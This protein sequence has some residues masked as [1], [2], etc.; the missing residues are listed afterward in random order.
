MRRQLASTAKLCDSI[1]ANAAGDDGDDGDDTNAALPSF[2]IAAETQRR[3]AAARVRLVDAAHS[4]LQD[5]RRASPARNS[6][7]P[8]A[9]TQGS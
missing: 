4:V 9:R 7:R 6:S 8:A 5:R 3:I 2:R 1:E